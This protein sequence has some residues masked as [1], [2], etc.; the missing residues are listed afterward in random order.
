[1]K[2][3]YSQSQV[4]KF[5]AH[6]LHAFRNIKGVSQPE[7]AERTGISRSTIVNLEKGH[8]G[9]SLFTAHALAAGLEVTLEAL[10]SPPLK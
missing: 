3:S 1:M 2:K 7:L 6:N 10:V 5:F 8:S 4:C 9:P